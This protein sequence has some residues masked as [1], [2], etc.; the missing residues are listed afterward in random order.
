MKKLTL[1]QRASRMQNLK[2]TAAANQTY[3]RRMYIHDYLPGHTIYAM[4]MTCDDTAF[5]RLKAL[6]EAGVDVIRITEQVQDTAFA[7]RFADLCHYFGIRVIFTVDNWDGAPGAEWRSNVMPQLLNI[8][9]FGGFDGICADMSG[10]DPNC[11]CAH[12]PELED[13]LWQ[14]Y[15]RVKA[16]GGI[17]VLR[18]HNDQEPACIDKT[19]DYLLTDG[20]K[21]MLHTAGYVM[22]TAGSFARTIP[23]LQLPLLTEDNSEQWER[24]R[25]LYAPMVEENTLAY[26]DL[27]EST[28][29]LSSLPEDVRVSMFI[30]DVK[31][32]AVSNLS[33]KPFTL[34]LQAEWTDRIAGISASAFT[35]P[36][37]QMLLLQA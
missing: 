28:E 6:A 21:P 19:Y 13:M 24:Y 26:L 33:D 31:Y 2:A 27:K 15:T 12:D 22:P 7:K 18:T 4:G 1:E 30:N 16:M 29:I 23:F 14:L 10:W 32:L 37:A 36:P 20:C 9:Q 34:E 17:L 8:V 11:D 3:G 5:N 25:K 35:V